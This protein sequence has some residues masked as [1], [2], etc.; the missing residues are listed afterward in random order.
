M[1]QYCTK[2]SLPP[3]FLRV[4]SSNPTYNACK[5]NAVPFAFLTSSLHFTCYHPSSTSCCTLHLPP[6]YQYLFV[7]M[8]TCNKPTPYQYLHP[9]CIPATFVHPCCIPATFVHP[10]CIPANYLHPCC[11]ITC[12]T[13]GPPFCCRTSI[14][15]STPCIYQVCPACR[16][17]PPYTATPVRNSIHCCYYCCI[18]V[19]WHNYLVL[20]V[21]VDLTFFT[22]YTTLYT[23]PCLHC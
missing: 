22:L 5:Y 8:V 2:T 4:C 19:P 3:S 6:V 7:F 15:C 23:L 17:V 14:H 20:V 12:R 13:V 10:C 11:I 16:A 1:P 9:C 18:P 21:L